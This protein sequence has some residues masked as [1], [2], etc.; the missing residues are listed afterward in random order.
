M[1]PAA[2]PAARPIPLKPAHSPIALTRSR[3]TGYAAASRASEA[4]LSAAAPMPC[5]TRPVISHPIEGATEHSTDATVNTAT[6]ARNTRLRPKRSAKTPPD[7][8]SMATSST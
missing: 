8:N 2:G 4:G 6:P 7:S 3:G 5:T 1:P